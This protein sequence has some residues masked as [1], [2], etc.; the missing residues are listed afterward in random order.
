M[1]TSPPTVEYSLTELGYELKPAI[2][3]IASVGH[4]IKQFR[5][6][7]AVERSG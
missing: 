7:Q 3:A 4:R 2:E 6:D 1:P 5:F